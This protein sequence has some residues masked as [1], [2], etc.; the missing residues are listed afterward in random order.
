[1]HKF[2]VHGNIR[3]EFRNV[4]AVCDVAT[5]FS[6]DAHFFAQIRVLF[7]DSG[8]GTH[9]GCGCCRHQ[10]GRASADDNNLQ[11]THLCISIFKLYDH[12]VN[13]IAESATFY[14]VW[15]KQRI[16]KKN[17]ENKRKCVYN[18]K[19]R[20]LII[21]WILSNIIEVLALEGMEC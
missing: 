20:R 15:K 8:G 21:F 7:Y 4:G 3:N 5:S 10:S 19:I 6:R 9:G 11:K 12:S 13:S 2:A 1:M 16:R 14:N 18:F 17:G